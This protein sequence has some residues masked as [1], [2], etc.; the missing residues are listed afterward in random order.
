MA[1][2]IDRIDLAG[3]APGTRHTVTVHRFGRSGARPKAYIQGGIHADELPALLCLSHLVPRLAKADHAGA[4]SGE[5]IVV[6]AANPIGLAQAVNGQQL[7]RVALDGSGNFNRRWPD[8]PALVAAA[9]DGPLSPTDHAAN[10]ARIRATVRAVVADLPDASTPDSLRKQL[11]G[12][13]VDADICLDVHCD[14]D[15]VLHLYV[16]ESLWPA[17]ADLSAEIGSRATLTSDRSGG[18]PFDETVGGIWWRLAEQHP[19]AAIPPACQSATIEL[20]GQAD[21][22]DAIAAGDAAALFRFL[23]RRG[24][25][26]GDPGPP[27]DPVCAASRLDATDIVQAPVP[28]IICYRVAPGATVRAGDV[29]AEILDP[30]ADDPA[31]ARVPVRTGAT[32]LVISRRLLKLARA[33]DALAKV[34]GTDPLAS[35]QTG[36]LTENNR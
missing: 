26:A 1:H 5:V 16:G 11:L 8:L 25:V 4:V 15:A 2:A 6:P 18:G 36:M 33:G 30:M 31:R 34:A 3:P 28:G 10:V 13:C 23:Q 22:D 14:L 20:R 35:R 29:I 12:L 32:G 27:P 9:L 21:T 7:G 17:L 19:D 24:L